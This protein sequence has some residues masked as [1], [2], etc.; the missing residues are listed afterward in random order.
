M[1][2][3]GQSLVD[4]YGA[5]RQ[6]LPDADAPTSLR[7]LAHIL[8]TRLRPTRT[9]LF[10]P[11]L[12]RRGFVIWKLLARLG[13]RI[14]NDPDDSPDAVILWQDRTLIDREA[15]AA[16][17]ERFPR[18]ING[19]CTDISKSHVGTCFEEAFGYAL[20]V[21]PRRYVGPM[22]AKSE[23]NATHDG[24]LQIGPLSEAAP[25]TAYQRLVESKITCRLCVDYRVPVI[26]GRLPLA[27]LRF[28]RY[29]ERFVSN[30]ENAVLADIDDVL[31]PWEQERV[32]D[33]SARIGL[34]YGELDVLRDRTDDQIYVVDCNKTPWGP[35]A[36]PHRDDR[37]EAIGRMLP[38]VDAMVESPLPAPLS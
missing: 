29:D 37:A 32:V 28:R 4:D 6:C 22:V 14:T 11:E 36:L 3:D 25:R 27:Y 26:D 15:Y 7:A 13:I 5:L 31:T 2:L 18:V 21:D 8:R 19:R 34:D 30:F 35:T 1:V 38:F 9:V 20:A 16:V 10:Y 12:P 23:A 17:L 24:R 33:F